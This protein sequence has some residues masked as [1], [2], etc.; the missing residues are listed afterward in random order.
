[1]ELF[2]DRD[3]PLPI[4]EQITAQIRLLV[5]SGDLQAGGPL[6]TIK[7]TALQL[8][9]NPN[10]VAGAYRTLEEEGYLTQRKRAGTTVAQLPPKRMAG[11]LAERLAAEAAVK[12]RAAGLGVNELVRAVAAQ[13]ALAS[14]RPKLRIAVLAET[15]LQAGVMA[16]R[17]EAILGDEAVCLP[18]TPE[19]Y[20]SV[21]Y[22]LTIVDP[23]LTARL[24]RPE[25][26]AERPLP[27]HLEYSPEFPSGAD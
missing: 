3:S 23:R 20:D 13:G 5:D 12:A 10:T 7:T 2:I 27:T 25:A 19:R 1:M 17:T 22:H 18:L 16:K 6:P 11:I 21:D 4:H 24:F 26:S 15:E 8:G 9:L 14:A